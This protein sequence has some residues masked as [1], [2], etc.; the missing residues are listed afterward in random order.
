MS[1]E[2]Y[3]EKQKLDAPPGFTPGTLAQDMRQGS[4]LSKGEPM[5]LRAA[6]RQGS[7]PKKAFDPTT[8]LKRL[9]KQ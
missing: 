9:L 5:G 3:Y 1:L 7:S 2:K 8:S 6:M 4:A